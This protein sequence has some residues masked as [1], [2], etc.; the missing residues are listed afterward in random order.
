[1]SAMI[2]NSIMPLIIVSTTIKAKLDFHERPSRDGTQENPG[3]DY[4]STVHRQTQLETVTFDAVQPRKKS[5]PARSKCG[6]F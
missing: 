1:M 3:L 6:S 2:M 5:Q 4:D